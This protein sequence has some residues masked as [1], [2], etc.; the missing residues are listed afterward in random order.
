MLAK[1]RCTG[2]IGV[3]SLRT[4]LL[5]T[6]SKQAQYS[7]NIYR[8]GVPGLA[9]FAAPFEK[10]ANAIA[11][12]TLGGRKL[13]KA[14]NTAA[15]I[16]KLGRSDAQTTSYAAALQR[17]VKEYRRLAGRSK[18]KRGK[19]GATR[20][21]TFKRFSLKSG[22]KRARVKVRLSARTLRSLRREAGKSA[23]FRSA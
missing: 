1:P 4:S 7:A 18:K 21:T 16:A 15:V 8:F 12:Q 20:G 10:S 19:P 13:P 17:A 14:V 3:G 22:R 9:G 23:A 11:K 6:L 5:R 2:T